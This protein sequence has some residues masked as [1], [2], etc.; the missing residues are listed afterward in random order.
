MELIKT[1]IEIINKNSGVIAFCA[2]IV[3]VVLY[4]MNRCNEK[5][6]MRNELEAMDEHDIFPK[7]DFE[8]NLDIRRKTLEKNLKI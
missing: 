2:I 5:R 4:K 3:S 6:S 1:L 8:R 7:S